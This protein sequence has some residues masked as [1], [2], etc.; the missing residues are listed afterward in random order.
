MN[1]R[2]LFLIMILISMLAISGVNAATDL[3]DDAAAIDESEAI[4]IDESEPATID[5]SSDLE[6][7]DSDDVIDT[8][9]KDSNILKESEDSDDLPDGEKKS[10]QMSIDVVAPYFE[11]EAT[12]II[13]LTD[14]ITD[15]P[16]YGADVEVFVDNISIGVYKSEEEIYFYCDDIRD[17]EVSAHFN[18]TDE[19]NEADASVEFEVYKSPTKMH[20]D[21]DMVHYGS[22]QMDLYI[23]LTDQRTGLGVMEGTNVTLTLTSGSKKLT[24]TEKTKA[25]GMVYFNIK[26]LTPGVW[27]LHAVNKE[28]K[29]YEACDLNHTITS[30][31]MSASDITTVFQSGKYI[32]AT[33]KD[34][35]GKAIEKGKVTIKINGKTYT[36]TT[37]SKGQA[38]ILINLIPNTYTVSYVFAG[39]VNYMKS[40]A[41]SKF[42][43]K[44]ATPK[45]TAKAASFKR[46]VKIKKYSV[47][48]KN[49]KNAAM[50][51]TDISLKVN[52][53][54][55]KVKTNSKGVATFKI[56]N[57]KKKGTYK[58]TVIYQNSKYYNRVTKTVK[59]TVK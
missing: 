20:I 4:S 9:D 35:N 50:K 19:Y 47:T 27:K 41:S 14:S 23:F 46:T 15:E 11:E 44:K 25:D 13:H 18:E 40:S 10:V 49:H 45:L 42:I 17:Y 51:S 57:L 39:N 3:T 34:Y 37:D 16:I 55:F 30:S 58:A 36:R 21:K 59:I 52:G 43:V 53:K 22:N 32:V 54:T 1:K 6:I 5:E 7:D 38:K 31:K 12:F 28:S 26:N 29:W 8:K 48:L 56:T 24:Y 33:L 2:Y